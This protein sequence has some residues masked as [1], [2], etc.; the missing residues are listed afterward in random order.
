MQQEYEFVLK[1][2]KLPSYNRISYIVFILNAAAL[3]F[4]AVVTDNKQFQR[5]AFTGSIICV[6]WTVLNLL[7]YYSTSY[8]KLRFTPGYLFIFFVWIMLHQYW[9]A[10]VIVLL[11]VLDYYSRRELLV[12][13][14]KERVEYPSFP[15]KIIEW[16]QLQNVV[17]KDGLLTI[18]FTNNKMVQAEVDEET[19]TEEEAAFNLFTA[20]C[21]LTA[22][23]QQNEHAD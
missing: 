9:A 22:P 23:K 2:E 20:Q 17:L 11:A 6:V 12:R 1:T 19:F 5:Y 15:A 13:F 4:I 7:R 10:A 14:T 21:I 18:D 16:Q 3:F 8:Q